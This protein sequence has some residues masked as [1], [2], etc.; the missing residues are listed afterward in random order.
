MS[1]YNAVKLLVIIMPL[2]F[3][4][5][6]ASADNWYDTIKI[7]GDLRYRHEMKKTG[8]NDP[9]H[10]QRL[11]ARLAITGKVSPE[12]DA[13]VQLATGSTDPVSTNQTLT[14]SFSSKDVRLDM[15]YFEY[16]PIKT[17]GVSIEGGKFHNPFF[18]PGSSELIWDSDI[19]PEGGAVNYTQDFNN[20]TLTLIGAGLWIEERSKGN[21]SYLAAFQGV[22]RFNFNEKK[23][24]LA[25]GGSYFNYVNSKGYPVFF[26]PEDPMGN[27]AVEVT[28]GE[29]SYFEYAEDYELFEAMGELTHHFAPLPVTVMGD[30]VTNTAADSLNTGW[31]L[32][33]RIGKAKKQ[34]S[35]GVRYIYRRV[36]KDAVIGIF[37]DSDFR[38]GG[39]DARGHEFGGSYMLTDNAAFDFTYFINQIGLQQADPTDFNRMQIDLQLKF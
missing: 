22:S 39:T 34:G 3:F 8:D 23:T 1:K 28:S 24:S 31:L 4:A 27:T 29:T 38:N 36:E 37:T 26:G 35:W 33:I 17:P 21:D 20:V 30:Y 32:G 14:G 19:S 6:R 18:K 25:V 12:I 10:R 2:L 15:A 16:K 9:E 13:T 11:R 7:K 5:G